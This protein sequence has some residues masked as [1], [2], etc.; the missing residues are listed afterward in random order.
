MGISIGKLSL[1]TACGGISPA[2]TLPVALDVGTD[3]LQLLAD[4]LYMGMRHP[5]VRGEEYLA[6]VDRFIADHPGMC[7]VHHLKGACTKK[8]CPH[9]HGDRIQFGAANHD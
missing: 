5:R 4:P 9:T 7:W 8:D 1:Y 3:N 2:Y 6:F